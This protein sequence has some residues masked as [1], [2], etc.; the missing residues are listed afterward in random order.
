MAGFPPDGGGT[1]AC[2]CSQASVHAVMCDDL[3]AD[4]R[5]CAPD[6]G[7]PSRLMAG[8][9]LLVRGAAGQGGTRDAVLCVSSARFEGF[10][11]YVAGPC[12]TVWELING[13]EIRKSAVARLQATGM[14]H[15]TATRSSALTSVSCGCGSSGSQKKMSSSIA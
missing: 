2:T 9:K 12:S 15:S 4:A 8:M 7:P 1:G 10:S 14:F 5:I 11:S 6:A 3:R 13:E